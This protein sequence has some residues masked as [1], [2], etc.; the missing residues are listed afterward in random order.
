V[1]DKTLDDLVLDNRGFVY[2]MAK[3]YSS[4]GVP[5]NDLV[6]AGMLGLVIAAKKY[7]VGRE[8][9]FISFATCWVQH[10]MIKVIRETRF[11]CRIP[12]NLNKVINQ[13]RRGEL[14]DTDPALADIMPL[15]KTPEALQF[16]DTFSFGQGVVDRVSVIQALETVD[17]RT[18]EMIKML[19]GIERD[20]A[21]NIPEISKAFS[22]SRQRVRN[23]I[24][25]GLLIIRKALEK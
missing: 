11:P 16:N 4:S 19:F 7:D 14:E 24:K 17:F 22:L 10:E 8:V 5:F 21:C 25:A 2:D 20:D 13:A 18:R 1:A 9:K 12:L 23:I 6:N 3:N 15:L